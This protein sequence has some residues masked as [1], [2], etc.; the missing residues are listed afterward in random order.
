MSTF[1]IANESTPRTSIRSAMTVTESG[2]RRANSTIHMAC[3]YLVVSRGLVYPH[4][5][6]GC[7]RCAGCGW[8]TK[9]AGRIYGR[10][11]LE[12][13][14]KPPGQEPHSS[15]HLNRSL[16]FHSYKSTLDALL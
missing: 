11:F 4:V 13:Y 3:L 14:R 1:I 2:R 10:A 8:A 9:I 7:E 12:A 6:A 15:P 5:L 16:F